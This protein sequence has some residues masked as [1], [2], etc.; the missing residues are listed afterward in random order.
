MKLAFDSS[1]VSSKPAAVFVWLLTA[2]ACIAGWPLHSYVGRTIF[3]TIGAIA[4]VV[5]ARKQTFLVRHPAEEVLLQFQN[6][7]RA[8]N[9]ACDLSNGSIE[10]ASTGTKANVKGRGGLCLVSFEVR[11]PK[12]NKERFLLEVLTKYL[13]Q[14][15]R[16]DAHG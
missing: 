8:C 11:D 4:G 9:I 7:L 13:R 5:I 3:A 12:S 14:I 10:V 15:E 6:T 1:V 16:K 2:A